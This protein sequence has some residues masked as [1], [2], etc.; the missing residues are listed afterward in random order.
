MPSVTKSSVRR[1]GH[2]PGPAPR[3]ERDAVRRRPGDSAGARQLR[4][5]GRDGHRDGG[6]IAPTG[7]Q[8]RTAAGGVRQWHQGRVDHFIPELRHR[9]A[10]PDVEFVP[11]RRGLTTVGTGRGVIDSRFRIDNFSTHEPSAR[12]FQVGFG[13]KSCFGLPVIGEQKYQHLVSPARFVHHRD[14]F[15]VLIVLE[16]KA[17][18]APLLAGFPAGEV[19]QPDQYPHLAGRKDIFG[20]NPGQKSLKFGPGQ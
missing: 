2:D 6:G 16:E 8:R 9:A 4:L 7:T 5:Q 17:D 14:P 10:G 11:A 3:R 1:A 18:V 13:E 15:D 12:R 20:F 19:L